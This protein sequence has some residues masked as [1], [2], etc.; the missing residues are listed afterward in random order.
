MHSIYSLQEM[1]QKKI[2]YRRMEALVGDAVAGS[3]T[4]LEAGHSSNGWC[5]H[6]TACSRELQALTPN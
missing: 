3:N 4:F 5:I 1:T 6:T 2:T